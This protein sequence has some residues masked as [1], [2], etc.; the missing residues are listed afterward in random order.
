MPDT[1]TVI[2]KIDQP[3]KLL[4]KT[5]PMPL[6]SSDDEQ[7]AGIRVTRA[8]FAKMMGC[9]RQAVTDWVKSGRIA[10]GADER[11]DPRQAVTSLLRT[12][13]PSRIRAKVLEPL[14]RELGLMTRR[15]ADL[16]QMLETATAHISSLESALHEESE[17]ASFL[18]D[19][20]NGYSK[21]HQS[22]E[23]RICEEWPFLVS[24]PVD[25]GAT[26]ILEW[27][28]SF[29]PEITFAEVAARLEA[30]KEGGGH[31]HGDKEN[32]EISDEGQIE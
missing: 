2:T 6:L 31:D 1:M 4:G 13:D 3:E 16:E 26:I 5:L 30:E 22:L 32:I 17:E 7:R 14:T 19:S 25:T 28:G 24:L 21:L 9:S 27:L 8:E 12:G 23:C 18:E 10:V 29:S 20:L 15:I 11:F